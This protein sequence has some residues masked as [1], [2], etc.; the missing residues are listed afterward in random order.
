MAVTSARLHMDRTVGCT[1]TVHHNLPGTLPNSAL[2]ADF[3]VRQYADA[4]V[5]VSLALSETSSHVAGK[6]GAHAVGIWRDSGAEQ[7]S[8]AVSQRAAASAGPPWT[9]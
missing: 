2:S 7:R 8:L 3:K 9:Q 1:L 5:P 6:E 4:C